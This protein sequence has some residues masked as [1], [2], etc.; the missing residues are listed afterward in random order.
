MLE[1][2]LDF[3][4]ALAITQHSSMQ[5]RTTLAFKKENGIGGAIEDL[6]IVE[7]GFLACNRTLL[8]KD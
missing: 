6:R 8:V 4:D 1:A 5:L 3:G 2:D 7:L